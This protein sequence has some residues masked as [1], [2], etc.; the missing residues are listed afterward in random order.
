[1]QAVLWVP[2]L[3][4]VFGV[5]GTV[6]VAMFSIRAT[7]RRDDTQRTHDS[8]IRSAQWTRDAEIR[9]DQLR[10]ASAARQ[11][12]RLAEAVLAYAAAMKNQTRVCAR[13]AANHGIARFSRE[14]IEPMEAEKLIALYEDERAIHFER[15]LLF[16][17]ADLQRK[18]RNWQAAVWAATDIKHGLDAAPGATFSNRM[19]S[20]AEARDEFYGCARAALGVAGSLEPT[21]PHAADTPGVLPPEMPV[22]D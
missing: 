22:R 4:S 3:T 2:V 12:E 15:L 13:L 9:M 11:E 8:E 10:E 14:T 19:K 21:P 17:N 7:S 20:A 18:A 5:G 6:S 16:A 1:M